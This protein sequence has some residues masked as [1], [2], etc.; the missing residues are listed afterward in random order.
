MGSLGSRIWGRITP[1]D[2]NA[3]YIDRPLIA[4]AI[5]S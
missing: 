2:V 3:G 5:V 1:I 4:S